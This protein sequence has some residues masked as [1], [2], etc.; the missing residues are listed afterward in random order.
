M[1][2]LCPVASS[3][4]HL[5]GIRTL[6]LS[7][8]EIQCRGASFLRLQRLRMP[9]GSCY[10]SPRPEV[11]KLRFQPGKNSKIAIN[12]SSSSKFMVHG[13]P[14]TF[15]RVSKTGAYRCVVRHKNN[16]HIR[17]H[18][19]QRI[20]STAALSTKYK[21]ESKAGGERMRHLAMITVKQLH[22]L[23]DTTVNNRES[24]YTC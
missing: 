18:I 22:K 8:R 15:S 12:E 23:H 10:Q 11:C 2:F 9:V 5:L 13:T 1:F 3:A 4:Q 21:K 16:P 24:H 19:Q 7:I 14:D 20:I 17:V 6:G